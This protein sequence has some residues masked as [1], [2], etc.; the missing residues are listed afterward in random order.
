MR[1]TSIKETVLPNKIKIASCHIPG[2]H[3]AQIGFWIRGGYW[4]E[5]PNIRCSGVRN[6]PRPTCYFNS[7]SF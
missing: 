1:A 5:P 4:N 6:F 7:V 3:T 2:A